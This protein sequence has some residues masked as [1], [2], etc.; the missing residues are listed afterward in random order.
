MLYF[1]SKNQEFY[2]RNGYKIISEE[3]GKDDKYD[4]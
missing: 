1:N 4:Y 3:Y 2:N